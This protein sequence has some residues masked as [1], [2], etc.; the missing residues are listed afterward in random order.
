MAQI[1]YR[2]FRQPDGGYGVALHQ[3][4]TIAR[5]ATG[6]ASEAEAEAWVERDKRLE[7]ADDVTPLRTPSWRRP[8]T[9]PR[10]AQDGA[11]P[12]EETRHKI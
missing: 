7:G 8:L 5:T 10:A 9:T 3:R 4:G 6:F 1:T 12:P 2:V 11:Q